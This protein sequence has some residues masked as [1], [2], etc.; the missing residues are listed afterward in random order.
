MRR[1]SRHWVLVAVAS[2]A[3]LALGVAI[4]S[5]RSI[6][7]RSSAEVLVTP[8][9][10]ADKTFLGLGV[11]HRSFVDARTMQTAAKALEIPE[12]ADAVA[13]SVEEWSASDVDD[14]VAVD[15]IGGTEVL[16]VSA[17][18][19]D[20]R[21]AARIANNYARE[22]LLLRWKAIRPAIDARIDQLR[23]RERS[24]REA[25]AVKRVRRDLVLLET[26]RTDAADPAFSLLRMARPAGSAL[27]P[28]SW[29]VIVF[30]LVA[31]LLLGVGLAAVREFLTR[32]ESDG[33][34]D[35]TGS[36]GVRAGELLAFLVAAWL[37]LLFMERLPVVEQVENAAALV[38]PL[39]WLAVLGAR[40]RHL[41]QL[42][43]HWREAL[44]VVP[45]LAWLVLSLGWATEW[46]LASTEIKG[47]LLAAAIFPVVAASFLTTRHLRLALTA[48]VTGAALSVA[49]GMVDDSLVDR[50][51]DVLSD[52]PAESR[53]AGAEGDP[54][55]FA[56]ALVVAAAF[57]GGLAATAPR[58]LSSAGFLAAGALLLAGLVASGSRGALA[59]AAVALLTAVVLFRPRRKGVLAGLALL[60][61]TAV[62]LPVAGGRLNELGD[63]AGR[64][65]LW[66]V[67]WRV[68]EDSPLIGAGLNQFRTEA[69][70][71]VREPGAL[72]SVELIVDEPQTPHNLYLQVLAETGVVG[73]FLLLLAMA[74]CAY[75]AW[76]AAK[77]FDS[78]ADSE[79]AMLSRVVLVGI[80]AMLA[81]SV[82]ISTGPEKRLWAVLAL[83]PGMLV[84]AT[85]RPRPA[86]GRRPPPRPRQA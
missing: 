55:T 11:I 43:R 50:P 79:G 37:V 45:L 14:A 56:A 62:A 80:V 67:A 20:P 41:T 47:W 1:L 48:F 71:H 82:F 8:L 15:A 21:T 64:A 34:S 9:P 36:G 40:G 74:T 32:D 60:L 19:E 16:A 58:R 29:A 4:V 26:V 72:N 66:R 76:R 69:K 49:I 54:N 51:P 35:K 7:Y 39:T 53:F 61:V 13:A 59:A 33:D 65:D 81:A 57:A 73:L 85:G 24:A 18:A 6:E 75:A 12:A 2:V 5:T 46:P 22:A 83:G 77:R 68:T 30:C 63:D 31:G 52:A 38:V 78:E 84:A 3:G 17:T 25:S 28:P 42:S 23:V 86:P 44:V 70:R 10:Q 27:G